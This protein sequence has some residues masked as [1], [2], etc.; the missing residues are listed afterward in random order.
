MQ[1]QSIQT[2]TA[3]RQHIIMIGN[4]IQTVTSAQSSHS[5]SWWNWNISQTRPSF[6]AALLSETSFGWPSCQKTAKNR[7]DTTRNP[8]KTP[9]FGTAVSFFAQNW[10]RLWPTAPVAICLLPIIPLKQ[11][12]RYSFLALLS[13]FMYCHSSSELGGLGKVILHSLRIITIFFKKD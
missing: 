6:G 1:L 11:D 4:I 9:F 3:I 13:D 7:H 2:T 5:N 12:W 8:F 10:T